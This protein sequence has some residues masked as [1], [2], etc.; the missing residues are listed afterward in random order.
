MGLAGTVK[1]RLWV[2]TEF[3]LH[4]KRHRRR[5]FR[6]ALIKWNRIQSHFVPFCSNPK[7][8]TTGQ[9]LWNDRSSLS[10][11]TESSLLEVRTLFAK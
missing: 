8:S 3:A 4:C 10:W 11:E 1:E 6:D 2:V 5:T 7:N 9:T